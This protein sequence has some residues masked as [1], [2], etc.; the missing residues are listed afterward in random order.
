[1]FALSV[2]AL[3]ALSNP[4]ASQT[5]QG[6]WKLTAAE[7]L[8]ADGTVAPPPVGRA[9][10]R[11]D[12][13]QDGSCYLQIMSTDVPSFPPGRADRRA[14]G[15][16]GCS[17]ATFPIPVRSR[18]TKRPGRSRSS[19]RPRGGP[20]TS[21]RRRSGTSASRAER[22]TS[23]GRR[24]RRDAARLSAPVDA[25]PRLTLEPTPPGTHVNDILIG[26]GSQPV[27]L[28]AKYGNRHGLVAGA[29]GTGKTVSSAGAG[30]RFFADRR[31]GVHGRRQRRRRGPGDAGRTERQGAPARGRY[32]R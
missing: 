5:I 26:K 3:L 22:C 31:S 12:R 32:G 6:R 1:M 27:H 20:T 15:G 13:R 23:A 4:A 14:D 18:S 19:R 16:D 21:A 9:S 30:R 11:M 2:V 7:D 24:R 29:T 25:G 28:L 10:G 8:R 17:A